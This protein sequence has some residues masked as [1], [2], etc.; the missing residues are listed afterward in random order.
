MANP[1]R[2]RS[3]ARVSS[4][5]MTI[6]DTLAD[7]LAD[8]PRERP[9]DSVTPAELAERIGCTHSHAAHKLAADSRLRAV[10]YRTESGRRGVCYVVAG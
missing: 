7:V 4:R 2:K 6:W 10:H 1:Q 9:S 5:P 8:A 3:T